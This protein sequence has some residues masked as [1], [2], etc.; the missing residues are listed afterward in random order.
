P[1]YPP[2]AQVRFEA[3]GEAWQLLQQQAGTW[4]L[5]MLVLMGVNLVPVIITLAL[6]G[7]FQPHQFGERPPVEPAML[8]LGL[9]IRIIG[10]V[11]SM[12]VTG[13]VF[14][15]AIKQVRG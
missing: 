15:M 12:V 1:G 4:I 13:G 9:L 3:I 11:I 14:R 7:G 6:Q 2:P 5:A 10:F 8:L